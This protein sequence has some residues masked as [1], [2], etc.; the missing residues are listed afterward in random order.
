MKNDVDL[1]VEYAD[2]LF[3]T[4]YKNMKDNSP[5]RKNYKDILYLI[6]RYS[7]IFKASKGDQ[8]V[9][10]KRNGTYRLETKKGVFEVQKSS[11][12]ILISAH[13]MKKDMIYY[14]LYQLD[15]FTLHKKTLEEPL[16]MKQQEY[17]DTFCWKKS[18][19]SYK[20]K[21]TEDTKIDYIYFS[22]YGNE[23]MRISRNGWE[24]QY[25]FGKRIKGR[26]G[27]APKSAKIPY[28]E[29]LLEQIELSECLEQIPREKN[30][31]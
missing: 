1:L 12:D 2:L 28:V 20:K 11:D 31:K 3:G 27:N 29:N 24:K 22:F 8:V 21:I 25:E 6:D 10:T 15:N 30:K 19:A 14:D 16:C 5:V 23:H 9:I 7:D 4:K 17:L 13:Y 18:F 26:R